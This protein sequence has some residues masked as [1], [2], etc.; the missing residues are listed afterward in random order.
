MLQI[1][2]YLLSLIMASSAQ[3]SFYPP[4]YINPYLVF[5][6]NNPAAGFNYYPHQ[7]NNRG[8][9]PNAFVK[10]VTVNAFVAVEVPCTVSASTNCTAVN[11][12][13]SGR[14][15]RDIDLTEQFDPTEV[16]QYII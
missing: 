13:S 8:I 5:Q 9:I 6:P 1:V 10:T 3:F 4:N 14:H 16:I 12:S 15:E 11:K 2:I 7:E